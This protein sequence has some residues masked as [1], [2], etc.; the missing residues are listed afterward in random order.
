VVRD[1]LAVRS[2]IEIGSMSINE[3]EIVSGLEV[4]DEIIIS[5]TARFESAQ[6]I[7]LRR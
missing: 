5:D 4:G 1:S 6:K 3:T 2:P 7:F